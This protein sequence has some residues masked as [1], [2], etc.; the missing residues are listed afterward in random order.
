MHTYALWQ[1]GSNMLK[2]GPCMIALCLLIGRMQVFIQGHDRISSICKSHASFAQSL[3][4]GK[5]GYLIFPCD[6][7]LWSLGKRNHGM[8]SCRRH[9]QMDRF[10][11][12][13]KQ[14]LLTFRHTAI[15]C[16][17]F[18]SNFILLQDCLRETELV[19]V[20]RGH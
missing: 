16:A 5:A 11:T 4:L 20:N 2:C 3:L 1:C 9:C 18:S 17:H 19:A 12:L 6:G 7:F 8:Q 14:L 15:A 10:P 13:L